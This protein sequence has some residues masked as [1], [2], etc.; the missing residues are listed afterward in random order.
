MLAQEPAVKGLYLL[1]T[2]TRGKNKRNAPPPPPLPR[3]LG[4]GGGGGVL[5]IAQPG[6]AATFFCE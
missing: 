5:M 6:F 4:G 2:A 1:E 3:A